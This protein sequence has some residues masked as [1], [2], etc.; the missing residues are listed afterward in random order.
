MTILNFQEELAKDVE[1]ILKDVVT[2]NAAGERIHGVTVYK[3]QLPVI[4]S[5]EEDESK[6][7]PYA[8]ERLDEGKGVDD[9]SPWMV[10]ADVLLGLHDAE[11]SNQ[12]H[13]HILVMC[14]RL[15]DRYA[16]EPLLAKKYRA[17]QDM[18]WAVQ[19]A[20][21]Y[22]Y[23]FGGVRIKFSVPKIGRREPVYG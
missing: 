22:P 7:F 6:F 2:T 12:G 23:F 16:A 8:I 10:T 11:P 14:Q 5:D 15:I 19:D 1:H 4:T 21:T 13:Q 17:E 3:Q 20:D 9:D 18:E